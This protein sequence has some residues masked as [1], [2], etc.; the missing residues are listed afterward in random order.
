M[1]ILKFTI[2]A[3]SAFC[4]I[5]YSMDHPDMRASKSVSDAR[6][7]GNEALKERDEAR[8]RAATFSVFKNGE[9]D[10]YAKCL[11]TAQAADS[12]AAQVAAFAP[13]FEGYKVK[14]LIAAIRVVDAVCPGDGTVPFLHDDLIIDGSNFKE[15]IRADF[16]L[17]NRTKAGFI[18]WLEGGIARLT[19]AG[20]T[21][22][23]TCSIKSTPLPQDGDGI[24]FTRF[25]KGLKNYIAS[26]ILTDIH[27]LG[28]DRARKA[29][30][31]NFV[32]D[33]LLE[34]LIGPNT[35][36]D[37]RLKMGEAILNLK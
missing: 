27:D 22:P 16:T 15:E 30:F 5:Q 19:I 9:V 31:K 6:R 25:T 26:H 18:T 36:R 8:T 1:K 2:I 24:E 37:L 7:I 17:A 20:A 10:A 11:A 28:F 32:A 12:E 13:L 14:A 21:S 23:N 29:F 3:V 35:N 34:K 33:A 4:S